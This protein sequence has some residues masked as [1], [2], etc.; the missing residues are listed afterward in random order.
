MNESQNR[1]PGENLSLC[2]QLTAFVFVYLYFGSLEWACEVKT[3]D[4]CCTDCV[5]VC[6]LPV[7]MVN[8]DGDLQTSLLPIFSEG[9]GT[10]VHRL[11]SEV[12]ISRRTAARASFVVMY[13]QE[14][15]EQWVSS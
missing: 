14:H 1:F 2:G 15:P 9:V 12:R 11:L 4:V 6:S 3:T 13:K 8:N 7:A 10:S 5:C